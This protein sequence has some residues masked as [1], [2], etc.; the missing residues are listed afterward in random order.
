MRVTDTT[1]HHHGYSRVPRAHVCA[2]SARAASRWLPLCHV[3]YNLAV[4]D[5]GRTKIEASNFM[6][7]PPDTC[8][9]V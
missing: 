3:S 5:A 9:N 8:V 1:D 7:P 6:Q 2:A 4:E